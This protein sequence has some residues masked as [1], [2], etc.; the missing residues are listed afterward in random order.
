MEVETSCASIDTTQKL[1]DD[2]E[3]N[4]GRVEKNLP[5]NTPMLLHVGSQLNEAV[6][7]DID[8]GM[9]PG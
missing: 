7:A 1:S 8:K 2:A 6:N 5:E 4:E 3:L 9:Q